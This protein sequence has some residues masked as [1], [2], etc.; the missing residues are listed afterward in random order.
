MSSAA[1][2]VMVTGAAGFIGRA[3]CA[4]FAARGIDY[5]GAVRSIA[6]DVVDPSLRPLGDFAAADWE[7]VL[8]GVD[9]IVHLAGRAHVM[10]RD[11]DPTPHIV[12]NVHV[13]RRLLVAARQARVRR[14]I[15]ASTVKVYGESTRAGRPFRAGD[16]PRPRDA[17]ARSKAE[18]EKILWDACRDGALEGVVLRVPLVYGPRVK[19]NFAL[20]IEA[21]ASQRRLPF[22]GVANR[23]S[24]LYV[25]NAV[26]AIDAAR[27]A[28]ALTGQTLPLADPQAVSTPE[29][30]RKIAS[31]LDVE[32]RLS[33][34]PTSILRA[35]AAL[36]GRRGASSRLLGSLE[37]DASRFA[38]LARWAPAYDV[39]Q[40][41]AATVAWW[42]T[43]HVL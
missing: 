24:L 10:G 25:G 11:H 40:G 33:R 23:R 18:A 43:R 6:G 7:R 41:I 32:A 27:S 36:M 31:A 37:V 22:A 39:D 20:L 35:G 30:I 19:G 12:A 3:L 26:S 29:L 16:P 42:R 4:D 21:V 2:K 5:V 9:C 17:Y 13:T 15:F 28:S 8:D 1:S 14:F 38:E 34:M